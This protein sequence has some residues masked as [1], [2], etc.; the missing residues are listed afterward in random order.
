MTSRRTLLSLRLAQ[1]RS[2]MQ[3]RVEEVPLSNGRVADVIYD[4]TFQHS[5]DPGDPYAEAGTPPSA[6][7]Q[8]TA[9]QPHI[10]AVWF[11]GN[12][13]QPR[14]TDVEEASNFFWHNVQYS[15]RFQEHLDTA[16]EQSR[17]GED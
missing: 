8:V 15:L 5:F 14:P 7:T 2:S 4:V 3:Y 17:I 10:Q 6:D 9:V 1:Y 16:G 13:K 11:A 12:P